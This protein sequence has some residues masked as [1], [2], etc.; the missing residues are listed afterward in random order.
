MSIALSVIVRSSRVHRLLSLGCG[1][2]Q[3][4]AALAVG[5]GA[6]ARFPDAY[7][8]APVL[9]GS[10]LA[11]M[12]GAARRPKTHRIDISGTGE[13]HVT[14]QQDVG[15]SGSVTGVPIAAVPIALL[16]G[17]VRWPMLALLRYRAVDMPGTAAGVLPVCRDSV[18]AAAWRTLAVALAVIGRR[19]GGEGF[20]KIR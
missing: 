18:D 20:D 4:A 12:L 8:L 1:L 13:L 7:W 3:C 10:A 2:A 14:V 11:L 9:A 19:C 5:I 16:P 15:V 17:S 6:P